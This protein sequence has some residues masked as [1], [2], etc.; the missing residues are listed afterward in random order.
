MLLS[1]IFQPSSSTE[2]VYDNT[3]HVL[4]G[5]C[6]MLLQVTVFSVTSRSTN[7]PLFEGHAVEARLPAGPE[8]QVEAARKLGSFCQKL[9]PMVLLKKV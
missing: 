4:A 7:L 3:V 2:Q 8:Q 1:T 9:L 5:C 6:R